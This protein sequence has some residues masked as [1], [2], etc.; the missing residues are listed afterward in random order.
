MNISGLFS[1]IFSNILQFQGT[2][3]DPVIRPPRDMIETDSFLI[4]IDRD[5]DLLGYGVPGLRLRGDQA[6]AQRISDLRRAL[7]ARLTLQTAASPEFISGLTNEEFNIL[8]D[9]IRFDHTSELA[10][11]VTSNP[12][13]V[14]RLS[15][16]QFN[17]DRELARII[18]IQNDPRGPGDTEPEFAIGLVGNPE[19]VRRLSEAQFNEDRQLV[20]SYM[21]SFFARSFVGCPAYVRRLTPGQFRDDRN[22]AMENSDMAGNNFVLSLTSNPAYMR[23]PEYTRREEFQ[24]NSPFEAD[25]ALARAVALNGAF[26]ESDFTLGLTNNENYVDMLTQEQFNRD[27]D[28]SR[29]KDQIDHNFTEG[30]ISNKRYVSRLSLVQLQDD[31]ALAMRHPNSDF[32]IFLYVNLREICESDKNFARENPHTE[33]AGGIA[34]REDFEITDRDRAIMQRYPASFFAMAIARRLEGSG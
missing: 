17:A 11:I 2:V 14:R 1:Q 20:R 8:R 16:E 7:F 13:Y 31:K 19:Y 26:P 24:R 34:G 3:G 18:G 22:W 12:Q 10:R 4:D 6:H 15:P 30:F 28:L 5:P 33:L 32:A 9:H 23:R 29:R 25:R 21:R 27:R